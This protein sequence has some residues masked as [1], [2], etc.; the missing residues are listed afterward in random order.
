VGVAELTHE[1]GLVL[2]RGEPP[3]CP[4]ASVCITKSSR[5]VDDDLLGRWWWREQALREQEQR[6]RERE[7]Q[8]RAA[9][10]MATIRAL[11]GGLAS[12]DEDEQ[13]STIAPA[14]RSTRNR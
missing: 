14:V 13:K 3:P 9:D 1:P 11:T 5:A 6:E 8:K 10:R 2:P 4:V 7:R 12:K